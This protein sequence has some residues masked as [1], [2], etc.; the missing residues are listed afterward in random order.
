MAKKFKLNGKEYVAKP[1]SVNVMC[2]FEES[3]ISIDKM[4][5]MH[6]S[7]IRAYLSVC[8]NCS[9]ERAGDELEA[10]LLADGTLDE[11]MEVVG[12][13]MKQS[14]FFRQTVKNE[15]ESNSKSK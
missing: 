7:F 1:F 4:Q 14:G 8:L 2:D 10:H 13:M 9:V 12:E 3:G 6:I 15:A 11:I 5:T